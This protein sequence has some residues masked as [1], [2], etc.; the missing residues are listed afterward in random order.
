MSISFEYTKH[1]HFPTSGN[2]TQNSKD[3][4]KSLKVT[5]GFC[6]NDLNPQNII[7][8]PEGKIYLIDFAN[9][10]Y[11]N[12]YEDLGY[13]TLLNGISEQKLEQFLTAY[14]ERKPTQEEM[15]QIKLAQKVVCFV[16]ATV[17]FDFSESEKDKG[18]RSPCS[19]L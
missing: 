15:A 11:S 8:T 2:R 10:G 7:L 19:E 4:I 17:Y 12:T 14:Y 13:L 6:H 9:S 3:L 18:A 5:E 1:P 16:S